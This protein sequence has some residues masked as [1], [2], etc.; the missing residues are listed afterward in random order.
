V[1]IQVERSSTA[2]KVNLM[3]QKDFEIAQTQQTLENFNFLNFV[4]LTLMKLKSF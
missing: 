2:F 1:L 3:N 4:G